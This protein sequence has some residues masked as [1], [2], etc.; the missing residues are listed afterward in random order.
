MYKKGEV[1]SLLLIALAVVSVFL[2]TGGITG[3]TIYDNQSNSTN[4]TINNTLGLGVE[5]ELPVETP[6]NETLNET[7]DEE[8]INETLITDNQTATDPDNQTATDELPLINDTNETIIELPEQLELPVETDNETNL[9]FE[10]QDEPQF[11]PLASTCTNIATSDNLTADIVSSGNCTNITGDNL[12]FDCQGHTIT[13]NTGRAGFTY[14]IRANDRIN[15]TIKNCII[16]NDKSSPSF[17]TTGIVFSNV[18]NSF[19]DNVTFVMI[20]GTDS[21]IAIDFTGSDYNEIRNSNV[22]IENASSAYGAILR[23]SNNLNYTDNI[24]LV[25]G[26]FASYGLLTSTNFSGNIISNVF[27]VTANSTSSNTI[28]GLYLPVRSNGINVSL[29][30]FFVEGYSSLADGIY[31]VSE[32]INDSNISDNNITVISSRDGSN[33]DGMRIVGDRFIFENNLI[34]ANGSLTKGIALQSNNVGLINNNNF[35]L[36]GTTFLRGVEFIAGGSVLNN[37]NVTNNQINL[38]GVNDSIAIDLD[39]F[40]NQLTG[41]NVLNNNLTVNST[42]NDSIGIIT[43]NGLSNV[44]NNNKILIDANSNSYG[45]YAGNNGTSQIYQ[46]NTI[47]VIGSGTNNHGLLINGSTNSNFT[48]TIIKNSGTG[49]YGAYLFNSTGNNLTELTLNNTVQWI[50]SDVNSKNNFSELIF[51][52]LNG[53]VY[54]DDEIQL[55]ETDITRTKLNISNNLAYLNSTNLTFFNTSAQITLSGLTL[56]TIQPKVDYNDDGVYEPCYDCTYISYSGGTFVYNVSHFTGYS[57]TIGGVN[58]TITK[59]DSPDPLNLSNTTLLNYTIRINVSDGIAYNV[60]L[61]ETYPDY[62]EFI[63]STPSP[64]VANDTWVIGNLTSPTIYEINI[65]INFT[66]TLFITGTNVTNL[67]TVNYSNSTGSEFSANVTQNTTL[68]TTIPNY[69]GATITTDTTLLADYTCS[70][71]FITFG[72]N[73]IELD[74]NGRTVRWNT[75]NGSSRFAAQASNKNDITVKN[76]I[77]IDAFNA[78]NYDAVVYFSNVDNINIS[79][80]T[81][82]KNSTINN[83]N[84]AA[85]YAVPFKNSVLL[86][87]TFDM[88]LSITGNNAYLFYLSDIN[89]SVIANNNV[90]F[91]SSSLGTGFSY[92]TIVFFNQMSTAGIFTDFLFENNS[93]IQN[94]PSNTL[95]S[96]FYEYIATSPI[97]INNITINNNVF[98][99][100]NTN[101]ISLPTYDLGFIQPV[102]P[103]NPNNLTNLTITN[104]NFTISSVLLKYFLY[105]ENNKLSLIDMN[106]SNNIISTSHL[107]IRNIFI[108]PSGSSLRHTIKNNLFQCFPC[109]SIIEYGFVNQTD[110]IDNNITSSRTAQPSVSF[111]SDVYGLNFSNNV[112]NINSTNDFFSS[113]SGTFD[114]NIMNNF[115]DSEISATSERNIFYLYRPDNLSIKNNNITFNI[116]GTSG[117][118]VF[119]LL[120][121]ST[122]LYSTDIAIE[123]NIITQEQ[124]STSNINLVQKRYNSNTAL[125]VNNLTIKN[126]SMTINNSNAANSAGILYSSTTSFEIYHTLS[127]H[128]IV[129]NNFYGIAA[130]TKNF[131]RYVNEHLSFINLNLSNNNATLVNGSISYGFSEAVETSP[132]TVRINNSNL[133]NNN[134]Q[135][136]GT[137]SSDK[138]IILRTTNTGYTDNFTVQGNTVT[139]NVTGSNSYA[140]RLRDSLTNVYVND[141]NLI[142]NCTTC[143]PISSESPN[144]Q[145]NNNNITAYGTSS[146]GIQV[147]SSSGN[148]T[149]NTIRTT[150]GYGIRLSAGAYNSNIFDGNNLNNTQNWIISTA[151]AGNISNFTNTTFIMGDGSIKL[152]NAY[153]NGSLDVTKAKLNISS[154]R[155]FLNSTLLPTFNSSGTVVLNGLSWTNPKAIVD[156]EDDG[157]YVN[158]AGCSVLGYSGGIF[159]YTVPSFTSY[160]SNESGLTIEVSKTDSPDPLNISNTTLLNYTITINVSEGTAYNITI[161][162]SYPNEA[163][164]NTSNPVPNVS[165]NIWYVGNLTAPSIYEINITVNVSDLLANGTVINNTVNMTYENATG[166]LLFINLTENTTIIKDEGVVLNIS[167][168]KTDATDPLNLYNF[169]ELNYTV[170][171]NVTSGTAYGVVVNDTYPPEAVYVNAS[172]APNVSN[173]VWYLG[174]LTGPTTFEINITLNVSLS[175]ANG[176]VINNTVNM[177]Y[178]NGIGPDEIIITEN[179]TITKELFCGVQVSESVVL[180]QNYIC[181]ETFA[182]IVADDVVFDC[183]GHYINHSTNV[184]PFVGT[185]GIGAYDRDNVTVTNCLIYD[186]SDSGNTGSAGVRLY[187]TNNSFIINNTVQDYSTSNTLLGFDLLG[188]NNNTVANNTV[189]MNGTTSSNLYGININ[190]NYNLFENNQVFIDNALNPNGVYI[191]GGTENDVLNNNFTINTTDSIEAIE[192]ANSASNCNISGNR[193]IAD[194]NN[195]AYGIY[196]GSYNENNTISD[197]YI[198]ADGIQYNIGIS[199]SGYCKNNTVRNNYVDVYGQDYNYGI[200]FYSEDTSLIENNNIFVTGTLTDNYGISLY[201]GN[202]LGKDTE[203]TVR[204][205]DITVNGTNLTS[206]IYSYYDLKDNVYDNNITV[207]GDE[208]SHGIYSLGTINGTFT[209][210]S[211]VVYAQGYGIFLNETSIYNNFVENDI[212]GYQSDWIYVSDDSESNFTNIS[213]IN[214]NGTIKI[215]ENAVLNTS[216]VTQSKLNITFNNAFLNSTNLSEMN[217]SA[218]IILNGLS[219]FNPKAIVDFEDDGSFATCTICNILSYAGGILS[220]NTTH[221]TSYSSNESGITIE[222]TKTDNPDPLNISNSTLLN[223]TIRINVSEGTAYNVTINE[224]YPAE[225]SYNTS[226]P[227]PNV[228]D[229]IWYAGNLT[230][231]AIYEINITVNVSD[232]LA[233]GT[234]INNTVNITYE[235][236]TGGVL[237]FGVVENTTITKDEI[238]V[239]VVN[240]TLNKTDSAD[241]LNI[242]NSTL[243]NYTIEINITNGTAYNITVIEEYPPEVVFVTSSPVP[244]IANNTWYLGNLSNLTYYLNITVNVSSLLDNGT[245]INN[246]VNVSYNNATGGLLLLTDTENTTITKDEIPP[247]VVNVTLNKTDSPD[248]INLSQ[249]TLLNYT[250]EINITNGTAYNIT[251]VEEYPPEVSFVSSSPSP[252]TPNSTWILG[253]LSNQTYRINITVNV[254][255]NTPNG[256]VINNTVNLTYQNSTDDTIL[257]QF[258]ENTTVI[259]EPAEITNIIL[260]KTSSPNPINLSETTLLNYTITINLSAGPAY[261]VNVTETYPSQ[262]TFVNST[263]APNVSNN[264]WYLGNLSVGIYEINITVNVSTSIVNG[265]ILTNDITLVYGNSTGNV[266][267]LFAE[268]N[269]SVLSNYTPPVPPTPTGGGG[270][271]GSSSSYSQTCPPICYTPEYE[272]LTI[273]QRCVKIECE[274]KWSCSEWTSCINGIQDRY[275]YDNNNCGTEKYKP[276][277]TKSCKIE[278]PKE[279]LTEKIEYPDYTKN[280]QQPYKEYD[281]IIEY[282]PEPY[283]PHKTN[284]KIPIYITITILILITITLTARIAIKRIKNRKWSDKHLD[285]AYKDLL[286]KAKKFK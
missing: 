162:E 114:S 173:N 155:A 197:N 174:N 53:S 62:T 65:T 166:S 137:S 35:Y 272:N 259:N 47:E 75:A 28:Y 267:V 241:P 43:V 61:L 110:I 67:I 236:A 214:N 50:Y 2:I 231:P 238:P 96:I 253:N 223:Y 39:D 23:Y 7:I 233:N 170:L 60:T 76:C 11:Q 156:L 48:N 158:C 42:E 212:Y 102:S 86:N 135:I 126:N 64:T 10:P 279:P 194:S 230:G 46:N 59:T 82:I 72:A 121:V 83:F 129:D 31:A 120:S 115:I 147:I 117:G 49:S 268:E 131:F 220:Y 219:W 104:N 118:N 221:F 5:Y 235:N 159:S 262:V 187:S 41:M 19:I 275:C 207:Y 151:S 177:S 210:N 81:I 134:F 148:Y 73:N 189:I 180:T 3:S 146:D 85:I 274:E 286:R 224:T 225:A 249:S 270:G 175:T 271:G 45:I 32:Q 164:F 150:T 239:E 58:I 188:S 78:G 208:F 127:N 63:S 52:T 209:N 95:T 243:L 112:I 169:T 56:P 84:V 205:N 91:N 79:N 25:D 278:P 57:S 206:G 237:G 55:N 246:T 260:N 116:S 285:I 276:A 248:P 105:L 99:S 103:T 9:T 15:I 133:N 226:N 140:L 17:G 202:P 157:S 244:D 256:S 200:E 280:Y 232:L 257:L 8:V 178:G 29:N 251:V 234:V 138:G 227:A 254:L 252:T 90:T 161:N 71:D 97:N 165:D 27:N 12:V 34:I 107:N 108:K 87:N 153:T 20:N 143:Y 106:L 247:E 171:V 125:T 193:I 277:L 190:G 242:S 215:I 261:D 100:N 283:K 26:E 172:P 130:G 229:N 273:C 196:L 14:G 168:N 152:D 182:M 98:V 13:F 80:N 40:G 228:S 77:F 136:S 199:M 30:N 88:D 68:I 94:L 282:K 149:N 33:V 109:T 18:T 122:K 93:I 255:T 203:N 4:D 179:T 204:Y 142:T 160:S 124:P 128:T 264:V 111:T 211:I 245:V 266:P 250:I 240:V 145:F 44:F 258:T 144:V 101:I 195:Y 222:L 163:S 154:N 66:S 198:F 54:F 38:I 139:V 16:T 70:G 284:F 69:C 141:N 119:D 185:E 123:N 36:N 176:T 281:D 24:F 92:N 181:P 51:K 269:T 132:V 216:D 217:K 113:Q 201:D 213:F 186:D 265:T 183:N 191:Y 263:P 74:C 1:V 89:N 192:L 218:I 167:I 37:I 21:K 184:Q 6:E 22:E